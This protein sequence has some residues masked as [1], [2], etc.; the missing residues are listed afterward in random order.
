MTGA[1]RDQTRPVHVRERAC[2]CE[3]ARA[4][5]C[6][7]VRVRAAC[8]RACV[9]VCVRSVG[10]LQASLGSVLT[11]KESVYATSFSACRSVLPGARSTSASLPGQFDAKS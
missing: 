11:M 3:C 7:C 1:P 4:C 9:R 10:K 6:A 8:A 2:A 5:A